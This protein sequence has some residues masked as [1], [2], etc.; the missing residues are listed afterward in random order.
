MVTGGLGGVM[1]AAAHGFREHHLTNPKPTR[2][3]SIGFLLGLSAADANPF[4]SSGCSWFAGFWLLF[5]AIT[6]SIPQ[7]LSQSRMCW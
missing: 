1:R 3:M 6:G 2:G 5:Q 4:L 7:S